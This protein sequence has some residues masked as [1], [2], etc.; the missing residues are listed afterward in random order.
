MQSGKALKMNQTFNR[1]FLKHGNSVTHQNW[2]NLQT[3]TIKKQKELIT[4]L[5]SILPKGL[6][7]RK[8]PTQGAPRAKK[9]F[10]K[11]LGGKKSP[12]FFSE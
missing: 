4:G 1:N 2:N 10:N 5:D 3:Q 7:R 6:D 9:S 11:R 12:N 8:L